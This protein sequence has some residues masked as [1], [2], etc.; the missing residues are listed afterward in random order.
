MRIEAVAAL[1]TLLVLAPCAALAQAGGS[2]S[3]QGGQSAKSSDSSSGGK[4]QG[5]G[6]EHAEGI[7]DYPKLTFDTLFNL[8][9]SG[10]SPSNGG[11]GRGPTPY[12]RFDSTALLDI[13]DSLSVD[14]LF[15]YK[16][17][18]PR[19]DDDPN[20]D[21]FI[22]QGADRQTGG[23]MKELYVRYDVWRFG[24]FVP[25]F[26]RA[27]NLL[28]GPFSADLIE[29]PE[30]G[31]EPSDMMGVEWLHVFKDESQGWRQ[32]TLTAFMV[33]R[34]FLHRSFPYDEGM[35]HYKD[36]GVGNTR[37][38]ENLMA[39]WDVLNQ[40][41]GHGA[42]LTWQASVIR[43]GKSY[44]EQRG[45]WWSTLNGDVAIPLQGSVASTLQNR[46]SQIHLYA[47]AVR[48]ENFNG[49]AGRARTWLTF[50]AEYLH[51]PWVYDLTTTQRWTTDRVDPTQTDRIY[52]A[53]L[54][55]NFERQLVATLSIAREHVANREGVYAGLRF[56]KTV[57][58]FSRSLVQGS[59]F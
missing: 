37:L 47:E 33:D 56:T 39:T 55:Y 40:P 11:P 34:T 35:V 32:L 46:Y 38:P 49:F 44:G 36:G 28:P 4:D 42:Q 41:L 57:S 5:G 15:Q 12:V 24:K 14:G 54:G 16:A 1:A 9:L 29:E 17:R 18:K 20:K 27:Y 22:N 59:A 25:D 48:R 13:S 19:P 26:G 43:Y 45:E 58:L 30:E 53:S 23:K 3:G 2:S 7:G 21:L 8:E 31:Y 6:E 10:L 51:G 50:S 52:T